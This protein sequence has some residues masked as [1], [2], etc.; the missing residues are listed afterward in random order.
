MNVVILNDTRGDRHHGCSRVMRILEQELVSRGLTISARSPLRHDWQRDQSVLG[1]LRNARLV[2]INGEGT[3]HHGSKHGANLLAITEHP[4]TRG[5]PVALI[6]AL[7]QDNPPEWADWLQKLSLIAVRDSRSARQVT[8]ALNGT[9][10]RI[11]PDLTLTERISPAAQRR[12][13]AWGDS[14]KAEVS[15][16]LARMA[17][18]RGESFCPSLS[19]LKRPKGRTKTGRWLR[20]LWIATHAKRI[21]KQYPT[22]TLM[23]NEAHYAAFLAGTGLH[24]TGRFHG[25]CY[26]IAA[27]RPF[28]ALES[29][30]WKIASMIEDA[31]L[32]SWR[33]AQVDKLDALLSF[34]ADALAYDKDEQVAL[35]RYL[36]HAANSSKQLFDDLA[37]IALA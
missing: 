10:P 5:I 17:T 33:S 12:D 2:V 7:Y 37:M 18:R 6:N 1:A 27:G 20:N 15:T 30:S 25:A 16:A 19:V 31:G 26:S 9:P 24:V 36:D 4:L 32:A 34:G 21:A 22:L 14:V 3:L 28:L 29:N 23:P 8:A 11:V 35:N 13:I